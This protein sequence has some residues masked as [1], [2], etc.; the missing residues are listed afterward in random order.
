MKV[1]QKLLWLVQAHAGLTNGER[2]SLIRALSYEKLSVQSRAHMSRNTKFQETETLD[3]EQQHE[4]KQLILRVEKVETSG[5]NEKL[6]AHIEGIQWRVMELE[7]ACLKMQT[8]ME[9][10]KKR[11]KSNSR[12]SNRSLPKLCS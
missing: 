10:I 6:K 7:R 11:T 1:L 8:Q 2:L 5:E 12:G 9:V 4:Q 3:D